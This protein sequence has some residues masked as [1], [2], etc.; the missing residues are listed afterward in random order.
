MR[1]REST[2][3]VYAARCDLGGGEAHGPRRARGRRH[4]R[5]CATPTSSGSR[6]SIAPRCT[7]RRTTRPTGRIPRLRD[8][9]TSRARSRWRASTRKAGRAAT[10][11]ARTARSTAERRLRRTGSSPATR[12]R[13]RAGSDRLRHRRSTST[14][15][16]SMARV[17][18]RSRSKVGR[19][20]LVLGPGAHTQLG[21]GD[22]APPLDLRVARA[23][24]PRAAA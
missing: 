5:A 9:A 14:A 23:T 11:P 21:W 17:A 7:S 4:R 6:R 18:R 24:R 19:D 10:A 12:L 15:R 16:T 13:L 20:V 8:R 22:N 1:G 2:A 3:R